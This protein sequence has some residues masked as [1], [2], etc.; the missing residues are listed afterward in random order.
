[1]KKNRKENYRNPLLQRNKEL[2]IPPWPRRLRS[3]TSSRLKPTFE[4][5]ELHA[6]FQLPSF[7]TEA[8]HSQKK[9]F[10]DASLGRPSAS[11]APL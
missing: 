9:K 5:F 10:K 7:E 4:P 1:M 2:I 8:L 3:P 6:K 11:L